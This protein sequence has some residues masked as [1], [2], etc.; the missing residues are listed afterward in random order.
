MLDCRIPVG[1]LFQ[2]VAVAKL[3][4]CL[5]KFV[6]WEDKVKDYGLPIGDCEMACI[7]LESSSSKAVDLLIGFCML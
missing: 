4:S 6:A 1:N 2:T 7:C 5:L 3:K